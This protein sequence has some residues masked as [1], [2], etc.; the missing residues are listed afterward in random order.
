MHISTGGSES[1]VLQAGRRIHRGWESQPVSSV[2]IKT[3]LPRLDDVY[4]L[5]SEWNVETGSAVLRVLVK[6]LVSVIWL[7]GGVYFAG[8]LVVAWP[9]G[10]KREERPVIRKS[11]QAGA[12]G[13]EA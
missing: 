3:V 8:V 6:P 1:T 13:V 9:A 5:L 12:L 2:G 7:G 10:S 4:V 11:R